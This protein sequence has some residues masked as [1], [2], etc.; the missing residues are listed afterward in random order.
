MDHLSQNRTTYS[1][2][3]KTLQEILYPDIFL[4]EYLMI[5][6][7]TDCMDIFSSLALSRSRECDLNNYA[8]FLPAWLFSVEASW[9]L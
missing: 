2:D 3:S 1:A 4:A 7:C 5:V 8:K 9:F 6:L